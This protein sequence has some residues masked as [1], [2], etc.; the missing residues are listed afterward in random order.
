MKKLLTLCSFA[1]LSLGAS[2]Q[3]FEP[4]VGIGVGVGTTG[5][6]IDASATINDYIGIRGGV[7]IMPKFKVSKDLDLG[8]SDKTKGVSIKDMNKHIDDLNTQIVAWN[9]AH[10]TQKMELIDKTLLPNGEIPN[11]L[12][13]EGK[14]DN[15]V[16]H[17][18]FDIHPFKTSFR[19]TVGAYFG[20]DQIISVYNKEDAF[21]T[22]I[23][24][25]NNA[26][27]TA[28][29]NPTSTLNTMVVKPYNLDMIGGELGDY[30]VTPDPAERGRAHLRK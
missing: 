21:F 23:N 26:I 11:D 17:I 9:A 7:D 2:A 3:M 30:F 24:Q 20:K 15:T 1:L 22:P 19:F 29:N 4:H 14:L 16:G 18:L 10:P 28:Q 12:T 6:A 27:I 25:W 13:I 8:V 5:I